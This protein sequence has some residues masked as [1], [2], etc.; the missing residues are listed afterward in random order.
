MPEAAG[1][2]TC[3]SGLERVISPW[4]E[5]KL[6]HAGVEQLHLHLARS[7][8]RSATDENPDHRY[9]LL[10]A[11]RKGPGSCS[12][13]ERGNEIAPSPC[14]PQAQDYV[15]IQLQKGLGADEMGLGD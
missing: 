7:G 11:R 12:T 6:A 8:F 3:P 14:R 15:A 9:Q 2:A 10:C 4:D 13:A 5:T 1:V